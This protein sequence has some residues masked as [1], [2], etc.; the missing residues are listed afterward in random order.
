MESVGFFFF[1]IVELLDAF[2]RKTKYRNNMTIES[3]L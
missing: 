1:V 2:S 3:V